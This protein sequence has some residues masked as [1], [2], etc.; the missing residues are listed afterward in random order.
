[1]QRDEQVDRLITGVRL[2][3]RRLEA[4]LVVA[5][6]GRHSAN[7]LDDVGVHVE[8]DQL[9]RRSQLTAVGD[10]CEAQVR[11]PA[12]GIEHTHPLALPE[13]EHAQQ[14]DVVLD[15]PALGR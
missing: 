14:L 9:H 3:R 11:L 12:G 2:D 8:A 4:R 15:L 6:P 1:M 10:E 5:E 13:L 7:G